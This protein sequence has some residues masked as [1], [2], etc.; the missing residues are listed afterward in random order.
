M[1]AYVFIKEYLA[2]VFCHLRNFSEDLFNKMMR[3]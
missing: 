2:H 3:F 1:G